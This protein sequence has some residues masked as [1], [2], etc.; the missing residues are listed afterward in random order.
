MV[1]KE[2]WL[3]KVVLKNLIK[4]DMVRKKWSYIY[5]YTSK[6]KEVFKK[7]VLN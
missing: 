2:M 4:R 7:V 6:L 3:Q 1:L 5:I